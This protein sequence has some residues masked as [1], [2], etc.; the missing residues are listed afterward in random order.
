MR[1]CGVKRLWRV[2]I[3]GGLMAIAGVARAQVV[4]TTVDDLSVDDA[5]CVT[6]GSTTC[7]LRAALARAADVGVSPRRVE[8]AISGDG[9]HI[10]RVDPD[11][12]PLALPEVVGGVVVDGFSQPG[13]SLAYNTTGN[14]IAIGVA[15]EEGTSSPDALLS[16]GD[17]THT[18]RGLAFFDSDGVG[19]VCAP[20]RA[21]IEYCTF[22]ALDGLSPGPRRLD[23]GVFVDV[24]GQNVKVRFSL[25][26]GPRYGVRVVDEPP[27]PY[28]SSV[29]EILASIFGGPRVGTALH[30]VDVGVR[31][32]PRSEGLASDS[33]RI[34]LQDNHFVAAED[35]HVVLEGVVFDIWYNAFGYRPSG[36]RVVDAP[37]NVA[38]L[39]IRGPSESLGYYQ[40]HIYLN[41]FAGFPGAG[42]LLDDTTGPVRGVR[43]HDNQFVDNADLGISFDVDDPSLPRVNDPGD[44]DSG[45]N[46]GQNH[47]VIDRF[48]VVPT[49]TWDGDV[50]VGL[51]LDALPDSAYRV[52]VFLNAACDP[53]GHG[54]GEAAVFGFEVET[55]ADGQFDGEVVEMMASSL[56]ATLAAKPYVTA[57]ATY[58]GPIGSSDPVP[59]NTSEFSPCFDASPPPPPKQILSFDTAEIEIGEAGGSIQVWVRRL[60]GYQGSVSVGIRV[61][62]DPAYEGH[63]TLVPDRLVFGDGVSERVA[64]VTVHDDAVVNGDRTFQLVLFDPS[65]NAEIGDVGEVAVTIVDDDVGGTLQLST[66]SYAAAERDEK[67]TIT[68]TRTGG[69][70]SGVTVDFATEDDGVAADG[71]ALA[72]THYTAVSGTLTFGAGAMEQTFEVPITDDVLLDGD[73]SFRVVLS[74][75][76]GGGVLGAPTTATV[77][78]VDDDFGANLRVTI[79]EARFG[80]EAA[81]GG[82]ARCAVFDVRV[83]NLGPDPAAEVTVTLNYTQRAQ[84]VPDEV[85]PDPDGA[86]WILEIGDLEADAV[87]ES[88][89]TY[90][91]DEGVRVVALHASVRAATVDPFDGDDAAV[92]WPPVPLG[93]AP[94]GVPP[95]APQTGAPVMVPQEERAVACPDLE[96]TFLGSTEHSTAVHGD[97]VRRVFRIVNR[98]GTPAV[99]VQAFIQ[100]GVSHNGD[101]VSE[102]LQAAWVSGSGCGDMWCDVGELAPWGTAE[103]EVHAEVVEGVTGRIR[104]EVEVRSWPDGIAHPCEYEGPARISIGVTTL[105][106]G[107]AAGDIAGLYPLRTD[108]LV[109]VAFLLVL[110]RRRRSAISR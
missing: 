91:V 77:E 17:G 106:N 65:E 24:R 98:G 9:P 100:V 28:A 85:L 109:A 88:T 63:L 58:L 43:I 94:G 1:T 84:Q 46:D 86:V 36:A 27:G 62:A 5:D 107:C 87:W 22:N 48:D 70:A 71:V 41:R 34:R 57:T 55:D 37:G 61:E 69:A 104:M 19:V 42:I 102:F 11:L 75:P 54:E 78:I 25:F 8:F 33:L 3:L 10:V 96:V 110:R 99:G 59:M 40:G 13:S 26:V 20:C 44:V 38:A 51:T 39:W 83:E 6:E 64:T 23:T 60:T 95:Q 29:V 72:G 52:E 80:D 89:R 93:T 45:P 101:F 50:Y 105:V 97:D 16:V 68:V 30:P 14:V 74:D 7:S 31:V 2:A 90:P 103:R 67:V 53:S 47:P 49:S 4:V 15:A 76:G 73:R 18:I 12:G 56:P 79:P 92:A 35:Q 82:D 81:C 66:A 21:T 32:G 108:A